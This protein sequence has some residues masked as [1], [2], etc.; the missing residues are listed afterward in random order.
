[1]IRDEV[2]KAIISRLKKT[3]LPDIRESTRTERNAERE[4][5]GKA[6]K[7]QKE[8]R[9]K[10]STNNRDDV[11]K[12]NCARTTGRKAR[13]KTKNKNPTGK[14][15]K[16]TIRNAVAEASQIQTILSTEQKHAMRKGNKKSCFEKEGNKQ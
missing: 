12:A 15:V 8:G 13:L 2:Q 9:K 3:K 16:R 6:E 14:K 10:G 7:P 1:M 5:L 11:G 4:A